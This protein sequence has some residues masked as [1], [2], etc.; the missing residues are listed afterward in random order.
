MKFNKKLL[1][2]TLF[3][4]T[5]AGSNAAQADPS[6]N[7]MFGVQTH[8]LS[9][10]RFFPGVGFGTAYDPNDNQRLLKRLGTQWI[11]D[12]TTAYTAAPHALVYLPTDSLAT[13]NAVKVNRALVDSYLTLYD[14]NGFKVIF[15][16]QALAPEV[17]NY[18][19]Y[20]QNYLN[21]TVQLVQNHP[22]IYAVEFHNEP[23]SHA[24]WPGTPQEYVTVYSD[25]ANAIHNSTRPTVKALGCGGCSVYLGKSFTDGVYKAG[26]LNFTD[27]VSLHPY[28]NGPTNLP[29]E[30][31][32]NYGHGTYEQSR[33]Y[34]YQYF[35]KYNLTNKPFELDYTEFGYSSVVSPNCI[36]CAADANTQAAYLGRLLIAFQ[37][38]RSAQGLP[39]NSVE[40]YDLKNDID[41]AQDKTPNIQ[42]NFG[43][44]NYDLS[45]KPAFL[46]YQNF[47]S[48]IPDSND[49]VA[50]PPGTT[51][52]ADTANNLVV[53]KLWSRKSD[54]A[55]IVPIWRCNGTTPCKAS[56]AD[57]GGHLT[58]VIPG[59]AAGKKVVE[60]NL[61]TGAITTPTPVISGTSLTFPTVFGLCASIV[62]IR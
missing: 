43:L 2:C 57:F 11:R 48:A 20:N 37:D 21:W 34:E 14:Q 6:P 52:T 47:V 29:P 42:H 10:D 36:D 33:I 16:I 5:L 46:T 27:G 30:I 9:Q 19:A 26:L 45:L 38:L 55:L 3:A 50:A 44:T 62:A 58:V 31:D 24:N 25:F 49:I 56:T 4:A 59:G 1:S 53:T 32:Q 12:G 13:V 22:S 17:K 35:Q 51:A 23:G 41:P 8:Q 61:C 60:I 28:N 39:L 18:A 40:S 54:G 7:T 15:T